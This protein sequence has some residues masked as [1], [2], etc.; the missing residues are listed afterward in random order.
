MAVT[1]GL[2]LFQH[3]QTQLMSRPV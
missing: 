1:N 2:K 3:R